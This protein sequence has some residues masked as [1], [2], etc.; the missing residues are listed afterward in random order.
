MSIDRGM[1][2]TA[3]WPVTIRTLLVQDDQLPNQ[4]TTVSH[5]EPL[6]RLPHL[7]T[8]QVR[9]L[10]DKDGRLRDADREAILGMPALKHLYVE[11]SDSTFV[12]RIQNEFPRIAIRPASYR[13]ARVYRVLLVIG[14]GLL[15]FLLILHVLSLQFVGPASAVMPGFRRGHWGTALGLFACCGLVQGSLLLGAGCELFS[16][17]SLAVVCLVPIVGIMLILERA[18]RFPGLTG[19]PFV[20][21]VAFPTLLLLILVGIR[22]AEFDWMIQGHRNDI[23][24][25]LVVLETAALLALNGFFG[26][27]CRRLSEVA[28]GTVPFGLWDVKSLQDWY[29][30]GL[31]G[32]NLQEL[33]WARGQQRRMSAVLRSEKSSPRFISRCFGARGPAIFRI[34]FWNLHGRRDEHRK[35][36]R[37]C[38]SATRPADVVGRGAVRASNLH[39]LV[40]HPI[41]SID[42]TASVS[43]GTFAVVLRSPEMGAPGLPRNLARL[44]PLRSDLRRRSLGI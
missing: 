43:G 40:S 11:G 23:A 26:R 34:W 15:P 18:S 16:A 25:G 8:L 38:L 10:P 17:L 1:W 12:V 39:V 5:L 7:T 22:A 41:D 3:R 13:P 28:E 9:L 33:I 4:D 19:F 35:W 42:A 30:Q 14:L 37:D 29:L 24:A 27:L 32:L 20:A 36:L 6:L 21:F 44:F 2:M 31:K